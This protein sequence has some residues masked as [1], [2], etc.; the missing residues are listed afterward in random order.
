MP[1]LAAGEHG[2][3]V[4]IGLAVSRFPPSAGSRDQLLPLKELEPLAME[5]SQ[6]PK[7][8][9]GAWAWSPFQA[10]TAQKTDHCLGGYET[11]TQDKVDSGSI[12]FRVLGS[13]TGLRLASMRA[14]RTLL[15]LR[16]PVCFHGIWVA[17]LPLRVFC[18]INMQVPFGVANDR[19]S[20]SIST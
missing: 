12:R 16:S 9:S 11:P 2:R 4:A 10:E 14:T 18:S 17:F 1:E 15:L 13:H 7:H 20:S 8:Q 19:I 3:T 5:A 6:A